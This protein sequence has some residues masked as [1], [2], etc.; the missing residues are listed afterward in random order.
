M[1]VKVVDEKMIEGE[2]SLW[3]VVIVVDWYGMVWYGTVPL[4]HITAG[5]GEVVVNICCCSPPMMLLLL[6]MS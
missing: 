2:N 3:F 1:I 4:H 5:E 6:S